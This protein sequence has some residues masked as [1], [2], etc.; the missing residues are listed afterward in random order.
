M[1][2]QPL[3]EHL[4]EER[5]AYLEHLQR[6]AVSSD[7][8]SERLGARLEQCLALLAAVL[9]LSL[10]AGGEKPSATTT[11]TASSSSGGAAT[12]TDAGSGAGLGAGASEGRMLLVR[13][14]AGL[15]CAGDEGE[16]ERDRW[17][18]DAL[19]V[20]AAAST[21]FLLSR[22]HVHVGP[23]ARPRAS[24]GCEKRTESQNENDAQTQ[25]ESCW[26]TIAP[27]PVLAAAVLCLRHPLFRAVLDAADSS[28]SS[29]SFPLPP[30]L[31]AGRHTILIL[32]ALLA[33][34]SLVRCSFVQFL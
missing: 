20:L 33:E 21:L 6:L 24:S 12:N 10:D 34:L 32:N 30:L 14:W 25:M 28:R 4:T 15:P 19:R 17:V 8:G 27:R 3:G 29:S 5:G 23:R 16:R 22:A 1:Q 7:A 13:W 9:E 31:N 18:L 26:P 2:L 11:S